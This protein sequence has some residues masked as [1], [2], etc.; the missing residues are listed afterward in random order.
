MSNMTADTLY[1]KL[2]EI[3]HRE[4]EHKF[5][6]VDLMSLGSPYTQFKQLINDGRVILSNDIIESFEVIE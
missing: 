5:D 2:L 3:K 1:E 4:P 6:N